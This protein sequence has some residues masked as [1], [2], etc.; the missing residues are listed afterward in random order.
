MGASSGPFKYVELN[1]TYI[2]NKRPAD[3]LYSK[4]ISCEEFS[5]GANG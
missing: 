4:Q 1:K 5:K 2:E 3:N